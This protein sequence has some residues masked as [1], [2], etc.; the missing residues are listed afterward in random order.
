MLRQ[1]PCIARSTENQKVDLHS[2]I[3]RYI[4]DWSIL[5]LQFQ[6]FLFLDFLLKSYHCL[7]E[8]VTSL[9]SRMP[10]DLIFYYD[11]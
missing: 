3:K 9:E 5:P 10:L 8:I 7:H 2:F 11:V 4:I 6:D 1:A